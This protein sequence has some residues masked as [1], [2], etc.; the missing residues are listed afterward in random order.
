MRRK[1]DEDFWPL[2]KLWADHE[3]CK[4]GV[5][6]TR[7][8]IEALPYPRTTERLRRYFQEKADHE[9]H[10]SDRVPA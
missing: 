4:W 7:E 9:I 5:S 6:Y 2:V 8:E 10:L 1:I 3:S